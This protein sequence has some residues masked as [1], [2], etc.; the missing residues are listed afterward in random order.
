[1]RGILTILRL[2]DFPIGSGQDVPNPTP[3]GRRP[4][5]VRN[6]KAGVLSY[7]AFGVVVAATVTALLE[8]CAEPPAGSRDHLLGW[9]KLPERSEKNE[10]ISGH[11]TLVPVCKRAG[12]YYTVCRGFEIP[13]KECPEGLEWAIAPSSMTGTKIGW[14]PAA[15]TAYLAVVDAQASNF[16]DGRYG[17]GEQQSLTRIDKPPALLDAT[18]PRPRTQDDFIGWFQPVFPWMRFEVRRGGQKYFVA[19]QAFGGGEEVRELTPLPDQLGFT[20]FER[21]GG[22][23][24]A[25]DGALKRFELVMTDTKRIPSEIRMPL[26]RVP[27]PASPERD[28]GPS[29]AAKIG[30]PSWH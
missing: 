17:V 22:P 10:I 29:P 30:I 5:E 21:H 19:W 7:A 6:P 8:G 25:Y 12:T 20:G 11:D 14:D 4:K 9:F 1:M 28:A 27:A 18:A 2:L 15:Q 16:T 13:L 26:V 23:R 3:E 24:L